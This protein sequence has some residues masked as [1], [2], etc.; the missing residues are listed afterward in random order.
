MSYMKLLA[1]MSHDK[2]TT[3]ASL[4]AFKNALLRS[5]AKGTNYVIYQGEHWSVDQIKGIIAILDQKVKE[6]DTLRRTE[7][8]V[9]SK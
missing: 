9:S 3:V 5:Q 6:Y 7:K 4:N 1:Q 2:Q 8:S